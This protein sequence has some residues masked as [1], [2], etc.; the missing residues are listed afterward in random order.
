M[1]VLDGLKTYLGGALILAA[2]GYL[3]SAG[4]YTEGASLVGIGVSVIG[5]R[6]ALEKAVARVVTALGK[7]PTR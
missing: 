3:I 6:H 4:E 7:R 2:G 1:E 5:G